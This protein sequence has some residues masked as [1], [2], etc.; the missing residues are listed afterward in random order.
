MN[1]R[2][3]LR[4]ALAAVAVTSLRPIAAQEIVATASKPQ[5]VYAA[6]ETA[7]WEIELR[8]PGAEGV[9]DVRYVLKQNGLKVLREGALTL[10]A[11][12]AA[13]EAKLDEPGTLLV[14]L[15]AK[16]PAREISALAGAAFSPSR[17]APSLPRPADFDAFWK[18]KLA[19]LARVPANPVLEPVDIGRSGIEYYKLRMDNIR[20]S[21]IYG[22]LARPKRPGKFPALLIVQWAGVYPLQRDWIQW[23]AE[24]GWLVLD[25]Q[26]HDLPIDQPQAFYDEQSRGPLAGYPAIGNDDRESSYFLRMYLSCYRAAEYL[27]QRPDWDGKVLVVTGGSQG[28][29]QTIVTAALHPKI[30]AGAADVPAGCDLNGPDA[31][32][33]AGWPMWYWATEGKDA[34]KVRAASRYYDVVNFAPR[35]KCPI[36]VGLGLVDVTCP[37]P[38]VFA[39]TNALKGPKEVVVMPTT[40]HGGDHGAYSKRCEAW[41]A[42]LV[43]GLPAPVAR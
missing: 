8:G 26:A 4:L 7:R 42:D 33:A 40:G 19:D 6:G 20:G 5:A 32:R 34:A 39:M 12:K 2:T 38:G 18:A 29:L 41:F 1:L 9:A 35:V 24:S 22:Q 36:V 37:A 30:T 43:K 25:I 17:I 31:G 16:L 10:T 11:G 13:L 15:K 14:E 28:G 21:H 23:R 27:T 3:P